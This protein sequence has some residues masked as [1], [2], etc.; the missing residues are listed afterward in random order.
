MNRRDRGRDRSRERTLNR[1][2]RDR[3]LESIKD[4][5]KKLHGKKTRGRKSKISK[6]SDDSKMAQRTEEMC[7]LKGTQFELELSEEGEIMD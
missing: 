3:S 2:S 4:G 1:D 5:S 6:K 7:N